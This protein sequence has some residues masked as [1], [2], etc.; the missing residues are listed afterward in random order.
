MRSLRSDAKPINFSGHPGAT[1]STGGGSFHIPPD[2]TPTMVLQL[3]TRS[4]CRNDRCFYSELG[5]EQRVC[6]PSLV[7]DQPLLMSSGS[8]TGID[9]VV[10]SM[11]EHTVMVS[12]CSG[13]DGGSPRLLPDNPNLVSLPVGH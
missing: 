8:L 13:N 1:G 4:T 2:K 9:S 11:V 6:K 3:A 5:S 10:N 7:L 12:S